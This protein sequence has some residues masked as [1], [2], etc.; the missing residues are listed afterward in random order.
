MQ[1]QIPPSALLGVAIVALALIGHWL[2]S[3]THLNHDVSYFIHFDTWLL[4]GRSVGDDLFDGNLPMVWLLFM[5]AGIAVHFGWMDE[6]TAV[7]LMFWGY[8]L[9]STALLVEVLR[10]IARPATAASAGWVGAFVIAATLAPG[11]SFGQREYASVLFAMPY[12]AMAVLRVEGG[13]LPHTAT[14]AV[15]GLLAGIGFSVKPHFLAV[16]GLIELWLLL[17]LGPRRQFVRT[18]F[19]VMAGAVAAYVALAALLLH[20]YLASRLELTLATY[21]A[22]GTAP[23]GALLERFLRIVQPALFA[24]TIAAFTRTWRAH[25]TAVLL[26]AL[27]YAVCYFVQRKGFV[28]HGYPVLACALALLGA[29]AGEGSHRAWTRWRENGSPLRLA[30]L[31]SVAFLAVIPLKAVH[32][33]VAHWYFQYNIGWGPNGRFRQAVIEMVD[34]VAP[35]PGSYFYGFSTHPFPGFPTASYTRA[36]WSGSSINQPFIPAIA[37]LD[38]VTDP[39]RRAGIVRAAGVLRD[40]VIHD[41]ERRPPRIVFVEYA[42]VRLGLGDRPFDDLAF[43][44]GDPRFARIWARYEEVEPMGPLRVFVL[45][46]A[47]AGTSAPTRPAPGARAG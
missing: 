22:Y 28:Y 7:R 8:A 6:P 10:R 32:D 26:A 38:E 2:Q 16:P 42:P 47:T 40:Q 20:D 36:E 46:G 4:Q 37:R 31:A 5:P 43:Y 45:R 17:R 44:L 3:A 18:E 29:C 23:Y 1:R 13:R 33:D 25:H 11:F 30:V 12:L 14:M 21:W 9:L 27:G 39:K 35:E 15:I 19:L 24:L 34:R 41:F